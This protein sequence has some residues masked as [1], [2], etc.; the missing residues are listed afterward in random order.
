[1][2]GDGGL[3]IPDETFRNRNASAKAQTV[4]APPGTKDGIR[5]TA[6]TVLAARNRVRPGAKYF[7]PLVLAVVA[8]APAGSCGSEGAPAN[9]AVAASDPIPPPAAT[10]APTAR[11]DPF[12]SSVR[13]VL[14]ARCSPCHE[15]GGRMYERL[16]FENPTVVADHRAGVLRRLEGEDRETLEKWLATLPGTPPR[17]SPSPSSPRG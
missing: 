8:L 4:A 1:M 17:P 9:G 7:F 5:G 3:K 14:V 10:P 13:P 6:R 2:P 12:A 15:P 11:A 16:P